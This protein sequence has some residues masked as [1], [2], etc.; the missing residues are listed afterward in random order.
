VAAAGWPF[1]RIASLADAI[2]S[3]AYG[4]L[5][6]PSIGLLPDRVR[7]GYGLPW[8]FRERVISGWLVATWQAWRPMLPPSFR[9]MPQA[10][11]ADRRV[12]AGPSQDLL[13]A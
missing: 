4:W 12:G 6:W 2:P 5:F 11:R 10:L 1:T 3:R 9:H 13:G 7:E 8:G